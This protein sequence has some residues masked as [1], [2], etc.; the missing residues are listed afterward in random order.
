MECTTALQI[1]DRPDIPPE[2]LSRREIVAL[3]YPYISK[4]M[5]GCPLKKRR[6]R[7]EKIW[8]VLL[9]KYPVLTSFETFRTY[10]LQEKRLREA[11]QLPT[12]SRSNNTVHFPT[13]RKKG[14]KT[15]CH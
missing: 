7:L 1:N 13:N 2:E 12:T 9:A 15:L 5:R 14:G 11:S 8:K 10:Y 4:Q 6:T 3:E